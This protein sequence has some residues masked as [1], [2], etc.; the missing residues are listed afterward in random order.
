SPEQIKRNHGEHP[1]PE[2][3]YPMDAPFRE[4][5]V[6]NYLSV[7]IADSIRFVCGRPPSRAGW[8]ARWFIGIVQI[9][10]QAKRIAW[11]LL[12]LVGQIGCIF[13]MKPRIMPCA[14]GRDKFGGGSPGYLVV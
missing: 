7:A 1:N 4:S 8:G 3:E 2:N 9:V 6:D 10:S 14:V 5:F 13:G 12:S 11:I